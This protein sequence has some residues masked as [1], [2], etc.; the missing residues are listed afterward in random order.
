[1][2]TLREAAQQA[3]EAMLNFPDDISDEMFESITALKAALAE[4]DVPETNPEPLQPAGWLEGPYGSFQRNFL[5]KPVLPPHTLEW[6][7][8]LYLL[9][10]MPSQHEEQK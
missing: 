10:A 9:Y 8:P 5:W 7:I 6:R 4:P 1:M 3:L 2:T